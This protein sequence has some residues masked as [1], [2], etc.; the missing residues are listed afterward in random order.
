MLGREVLAAPEGRWLVPADCGVSK[1][2]SRTIRNHTA[3]PPSRI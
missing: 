1:S 2:D 3:Q